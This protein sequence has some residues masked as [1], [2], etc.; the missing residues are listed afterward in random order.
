MT[1]VD[2][3]LGHQFLDVQDPDPSLGRFDLVLCC[4]VLER[5][6]DF[7]TA[8]DGLASLCSDNGEACASTPYVYPYRN[9]PND[10]WRPTEHGLR[11]AFEQRFRGVDVQWTGFRRFPFQI[12]V[13][14]RH[15]K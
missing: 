6:A 15:P 2:P 1:D 11:L 7:E 8:V 9:D 3:A 5:V 14:A 10:F 4:N 12:F 13:V